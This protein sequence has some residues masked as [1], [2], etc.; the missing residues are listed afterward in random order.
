MKVVT[1]M[2]KYI[3]SQSSLWYKTQ[4]QRFEEALPIGNGRIGV[5]DY[6]NG[7]FLINEET[8]WSGTSKL[9]T[10]HINNQVEKLAQVRELLFS[11]YIE[12][13]EN[14]LKKEL[15]GTWKETYLPCAKLHL[16]I[17]N[18]VP[19]CNHRQ[20]DLTTAITEFSDENH[21]VNTFVSK[22]SKC[23]VIHVE[24][25]G[26]TID[27]LSVDIE[28]LLDQ[29]CIY[30]LSDISILDGY[31]PSKVPSYDEH[32]QEIIYDAGAS[33]IKYSLGIK[34]EK[35]SEK[36]HVIYVTVVTNYVKY[37]TV[38][39]ESELHLSNRVV[40][41]LQNASLIGYDEI[42]AEH[43]KDMEVTFSHTYMDFPENINSQKATHERRLLYR[44][45][46]TDYA[47]VS[48]YFHY[49]R[50]LLHQSSNR[51][52]LPANLQGIWNE[53]LRAPWC[54]NFT[55]N[56]N[57]EMNYWHADI[58]RLEDAFESLSNLMLGLAYSNENLVKNMYDA[59]GLVINHNLDI[60][61]TKGPVKGSPSWA[62]WPM[63]SIWLA[64]QLLEHL[65]YQVHLQKKK[66]I[67][68]ALKA[69]AR[70]ANSWLILDKK[71]M[72]QTCP[73]T[74]PENEYIL[75]NGSVASVSYSSTMD[76]M[77]MKEFSK[78]FLTVS[79]DLGEELTL[80]LELE[81]KVSKMPKI[82]IHEDGY[83]KEWQHGFK[84]KDIGHRHL[85][86]LF[87]FFPGSYMFK[88]SATCIEAGKKALMRRILDG[89]D[90]TSWHCTWVINLLARFEEEVL[91]KEYLEIMIGDLT[92]PNLLS[93]H[94]RRMDGDELFQIDG[95]FGGSRA[96]TELII[97][98]Y[99]DCI[100]LLPAINLAIPTGKAF[101]LQIRHGHIV[102]L[103]WKDGVLE[104]ATI[105]CQQTEA[106][107]VSYIE[108]KKIVEL[109]KGT[110]VELVF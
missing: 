4:A 93:S 41:I 72:Y 38:S 55:T 65:R 30:T 88:E 56:I 108:T 81:E 78:N 49:G 61:F 34:Q 40:E 35:I 13:G 51:D 7:S 54:S 70:F 85:S 77:M 2:H 6:G 59:K 91:A 42:V 14:L 45:N 83:L 9:T 26:H 99:G 71:G 74:S 19:T 25:S 50:Y 69:V 16:K 110:R 57:L 94:R 86:H 95:N 92:C 22:K 37:G 96:I 18:E 97:Q 27:T 68:P 103:V 20:L 102:D 105:H 5:M 109:Q 101:G 28:P 21:Q 29:T 90:F 48:L 43:K 67:Y 62:Y 58:C 73:S 1:K 8:L 82:Q 79:K 36:L 52:S 44:N 104:N 60:W 64:I 47:L 106:L 100:K 12:E 32:M 53:R 24:S 87:G 17:N 10:S 46:S 3:N 76:I 66:M 63:A 107:C 89:G 98:D 33:S 39:S 15:L 11:G 80:A 75:E 23:I 84:E 31:C